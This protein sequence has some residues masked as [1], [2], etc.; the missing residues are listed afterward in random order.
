MPLELMNEP[1][2]PRHYLKGKAVAAGAEV[3]LQFER[4]TWLRGRYGWTFRE[5]DLPT[6]SAPLSCGER[7][8]FTVPQGGLFRWPID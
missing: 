8:I 4:G 7:V 5:K 2:N 3:E 1:E 6:L